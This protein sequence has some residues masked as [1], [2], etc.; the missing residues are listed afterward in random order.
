MTAITFLASCTKTTDD[1]VKLSDP[2]APV[3][4]TPD[5]SLNYVLTEDNANNPFETFIY[6][7]AD[8]G[9]PIV[10][11]YTIELDMAGGDFSNAQDMQEAVSVPYQTIS[12]KNF[13]LQ[14]AALGLTP[15]VESIV[16][17]RVRAQSSNSDVKT[18]YSN[19]VEL[20]VTPYDATPPSLWLV[21]N[22]TAAG[23]DPST[24]IEIK[25]ETLTFYKGTATFTAAPNEFRF[26][27]QNTG[28]NPGLFYGDFNTVE[29]AIA[30][31]ENEYGE[32]NFSVAEAG[33]Y[34]IEI[35]LEN[36]SLKMTKQ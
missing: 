33:D 7:T 36:K 23:W 15:E 2:V 34:L 13:N 28:W 1:G 35:N 16:K 30:G 8:Y 29:G 12:V 31:P 21:G 9:L 4:V 6:Q 14:M 22:A 20:K 26:L 27:W 19:V 32:I 18:L 25:P 10:V 17:A 5:G 11:D 3:L 24:S